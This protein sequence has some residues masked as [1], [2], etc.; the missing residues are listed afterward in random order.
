MYTSETAHELYT[1]TLG[2]AQAE[3]IDAYKR[4]WYAVALDWHALY[5]TH[6]YNGR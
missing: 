4:Y 3:T 6:K 1:L 5:V 2:H